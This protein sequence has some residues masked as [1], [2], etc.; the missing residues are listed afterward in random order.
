MLFGPHGTVMKCSV[1]LFDETIGRRRGEVCDR[2]V[3][4]L[5]LDQKSVKFFQGSSPHIRSQFDQR[6][7]VRRVRKATHV[8]F[9]AKVLEFIPSFHHGAKGRET[10][11]D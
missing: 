11:H 6:L 7:F 5:H 2:V 4:R 10:D 3:H 8:H 9:S 1:I